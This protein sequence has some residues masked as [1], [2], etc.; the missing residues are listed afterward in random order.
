MTAITQEMRDKI[1]QAANAL[2]AEGVTNPTN[3]QVRTKMGGRGS[4]SHISPVMKEWRANQDLQGMATIELPGEIRVALD[5]LG[6]ELWQAASKIAASDI[7]AIKAHSADQVMEAELERD[8]ALNEVS[9]LEA[10]LERCRTAIEA[11]QIE[12]KESVSTQ[13][14]L[15]ANLNAANQELAKLTAADKNN[16]ERIEALISDK[17]QLAANLGAANQEIAKLTAADKN[18]QER[19]EA[20]IIERATLIA[21]TPKEK[22]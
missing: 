12:A 14:T 18:N 9:A 19:I 20:L 15:T 13:A 8:E 7:E 11:L 4:L 2:S 17:A 16:Q 22:I 1:I 21:N 10:E 3:V 5:R 6:L